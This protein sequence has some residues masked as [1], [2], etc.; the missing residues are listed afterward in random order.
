MAF[1]SNSQRRVLLMTNSEYGQAN[2]FIA[3]AHALATKPNIHIHFASFIDA[4]PRVTQLR[5]SLQGTGALGA[6]SMITFHAT[7]AIQFLEKA[8][9]DHSPGFWG[10]IKSHSMITN[11]IFGWS[12]DQYMTGVKSIIE[13][14]EAINPQAI[15]NDTAFSQG[16][17]ACRKIGRKYIS[18]GPMSLKDTVAELQPRFMVNYP[19]T[20]SGYP[21]PLPWS[22]V[23]PN[24]IITIS[25]IYN[26][27]TSPRTRS[28]NAARKAGGLTTMLPIFAG[29][30]KDVEYLAPMIPE[31]DFHLTVIP[32]NVILCGPF[33]L[34]V[35][36]TVEQDDPELS[37]WLQ[38]ANGRTILL[39]LGTHT[40]VDVANTRE[41]AKGLAAVIQHERDLKREVQVL[42]KL[43][44]VPGSEVDAVLR[45]E[46]GKDI[47]SGRVRIVS[48][49]A[50]DP[51]AILHER[52]IICSVHHGGANSFFESVVTGIPH[53][54]LPRWFDCYDYANR[55]EYLGIGIYGNKTAAPG[56]NAL[57]FAAALIKVITP[58]STYISKAK[59][60]SNVCENK[61]GG[62]ELAATRILKGADEGVSLMPKV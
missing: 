9:I 25:L 40:I 8:T 46:L 44:L 16:L 4:E 49:L 45:E 34:P 58:G 35:I 36:R 38:A 10:A 39:N 2:S 15:V 6:G 27:F 30:Q 18:A 5:D 20:S 7:V 24:I 52:S 51:M 37:K 13:I 14:I 22:K 26:I 29:F 19:T 57:E 48:W 59:E 31:L 41:L 53:V 11:N 62:R 32:D 43:Q 28:I 54:I 12:A 33:V 17:D 42:W 1:T 47:D 60:L 55:A 21:F 3:L 56:A 23:I 61:C 50:V